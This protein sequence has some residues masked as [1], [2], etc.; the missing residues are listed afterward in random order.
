[1][2]SSDGGISNEDTL[3]EDPA[4]S[5]SLRRLS[6]PTYEIG[7]RIGEGGMGEVLVARDS[8][9][10]RDVAIKRMRTETPTPELVDR[11]LREAKIQ[12]RLDHP[13]IVPVYEL[14]HDSA[15]VP[16]FTMKRLTGTTLL[17]RLGSADAT[18]QSLLRAFVDVCQAI[19]FAHARSVVHRDLKPANIILGEY[20]EVYVLDWG[21]ARV[22]TRASV[23]TPLV[24]T[25][26]LSGD[27]T[28]TQAGAVLGTPGYM[29]PEQARGEDVGTAADVYAL[30]RIL[31][32]LLAV[33]AKLGRTPVP[34]LEALAKSAQ[35]AEPAARPSAR[36]LATR[37]QSYLDGDRDHARR[38]ALAGELVVRARGAAAT[39]E[40]RANAIRDAG[41]A[42]ALDP[43]SQDAAAIVMSLMIEP[44]K[45][46]PPAL[47]R[48]LEDIEA[49]SARH[50]AR[51]ASRTLLGGFAV[52]PLALWAGVVDWT[53]FAILV[54]LIAVSAADAYWQSRRQ[55]SIDV[56]PLLLGALT[57]LF[58]SRLVSPFVLAPTMICS[59]VVGVGGLPQL[60]G[61]PWLV[62]SFALSAFLLPFVLEAAGVFAPT[63]SFT[64]GHLEI[65]SQLVHL[66]GRGAVAF[67]I[68]SNLV[69]LVGNSLF[70][71]AQNL[72]RRDAQRQL[73]IQAWQL[74]QLLPAP[75]PSPELEALIAADCK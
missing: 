72:Q 61:R 18:L 43:D 62:M 64:G 51:N 73:E 46:L 70:M 1:M 36:E 34:E 11:F 10:G 17:D 4:P 53:V 59:Y 38:A 23:L 28:R 56:L 2:G 47:T 33:D 40:L 21:V 42:L 15:G 41:R 67:L 5:S 31:F 58:L 39:P 71:R 32:E 25:P 48:R 24:G 54:A 19:D 44:P 55:R 3:A 20:G 35:A 50:A 68:G 66:S 13:A 69:L 60:I 57:I 49:H 12:A 65:T 7:A 27:P 75:P 74:Q 22:L 26:S 16:Y 8:K 63:W 37:V 14:G 30:G 52:V 45:Q 9:I 29:A 6:L